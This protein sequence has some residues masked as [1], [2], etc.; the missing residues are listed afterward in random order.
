MSKVCN[1]HYAIGDLHSRYGITCMTVAAEDQIAVCMSPF[2]LLSF[3][4][5][6]L[7]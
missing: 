5:E 3:Y 6:K 2:I 7:S 4:H 1:I